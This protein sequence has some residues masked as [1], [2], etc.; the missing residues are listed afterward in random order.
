MAILG[1]ERNEKVTGVVIE[2]IGMEGEDEGGREVHS[3]E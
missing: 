3:V 2:V 1:E